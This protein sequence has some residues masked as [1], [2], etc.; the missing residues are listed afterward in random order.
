[1]KKLIFFFAA[2]SLVFLF[3]S[4]KKEKSMRIQG[5]LI[6]I[7]GV[8]PMDSAQVSFRYG[9]KTFELANG[10]EHVFTNENGEFDFLVT[11]T[12]VPF[13]SFSPS[14]KYLLINGQKY[15]DELPHRDNFE[16]G[17]L[18]PKFYANYKVNLNVLNEY[19]DLDTLEIVYRDNSISSD[20]THFLTKQIPGPFT[21]GVVDSIASCVVYGATTWYIYKEDIA[22]MEFKYHVKQ[23]NG[24][25]SSEKSLAIP[26][27]R[28][29]GAWKSLNLTIE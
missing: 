21:S 18:L 17:D 25:Y 13:G 24:T 12:R 23:A 8:N 9:K 11:Y 6:D 10:E 26:A 15:F 27:K 5:R 1:M 14:N 19:T 3:S 4:C 22:K 2:F 28:G 16:M 20:Y 29:V 7:D